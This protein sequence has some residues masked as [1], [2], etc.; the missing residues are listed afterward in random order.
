M[1]R[2]SIV[3]LHDVH[4]IMWIVIDRFR[5]FIMGKVLVA[6]AFQPSLSG[7]FSMAAPNVPTTSRMLG[8]QLEEAVWAA[9]AVAQPG[10]V[11]DSEANWGK[12]KWGQAEKDKFVGV[13][14]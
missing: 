2:H 8:A 1:R 6:E 4:G 9:V 7:G 14:V 11:L 3:Y 10:E 5:T 13:Y 12:S